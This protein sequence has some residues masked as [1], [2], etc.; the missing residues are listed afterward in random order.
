MMLPEFF[1]PKAES[2]KPKMKLDTEAQLVSA[3]QLTDAER[4]WDLAWEKTP[5][6]IAVFKAEI[7]NARNPEIKQ[8]LETYLK[9]ITGGK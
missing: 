3:A 9:Q 2:V 4:A 6:N 8:I 7:A 5:E 1:P